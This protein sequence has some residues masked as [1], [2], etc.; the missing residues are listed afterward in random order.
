MLY[1]GKCYSVLC[2]AAKLFSGHRLQFQPIIKR[3]LVGRQTVAVGKSII[4]DKILCPAAEHV[5]VV[6]VIKPPN[7]IAVVNI[8]VEIGFPQDTLAAIIR[9]F[10]ISVVIFASLSIAQKLDVIF[11][12]QSAIC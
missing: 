9:E 4:G 3:P 1:V 8:V 12:Y 6:S 11:S 7:A 5:H 10:Q 2:R